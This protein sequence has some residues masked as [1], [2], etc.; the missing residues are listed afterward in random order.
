MYIV[1]L[2]A[3]VLSTADLQHMPRGWSWWQRAVILSK[4]QTTRQYQCW[5]RW[6]CVGHRFW[7]N[8]RSYLPWH[9]TP[10]HSDTGKEINVHNTPISQQYSLVQWSWFAGVTG[11]TWVTCRMS[12]VRFP[13]SLH[14]AVVHTKK[15]AYFLWQS[16][17]KGAVVKWRQVYNSTR[18]WGGLGGDYLAVHIGD[19]GAICMVG[20]FP[21]MFVRFLSLSWTEAEVI[22][23]DKL[24]T[25][26]KWLETRVASLHGNIRIYNNDLQTTL[27]VTQRYFYSS[28]TF[29]RSTPSSVR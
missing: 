1:W 14:Q 16:V 28:Q 9:R 11:Y 29:R 12:D 23:E 5:H 13:I 21:F 20:L 17:K 7:Q 2:S 18:G 6:V 8:R 27:W 26:N 24:L 3:L 4:A 10:G 19:D 15:D 22:F 25:M